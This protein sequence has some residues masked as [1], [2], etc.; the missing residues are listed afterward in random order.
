MSTEKQ[1]R[2]FLTILFFVVGL[3]LYLIGLVFLFCASVR[4]SFLFSIFDY[5]AA[6]ILKIVG[7]IL[8]FVGFILFMAA[9]VL[10]YK[11]NDLKENKLNLIIEGKADVLTIIFMTYVMIFMLVICLLIN[12]IVGAL[13]FGLTIIVQSIV[14]TALIKY[15]SKRR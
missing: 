7:V 14:N 4:T 3:V 9:I 10:L 1:K 8:F 15:Y 12:E 5:S 13:L 6:D 2:K 11:D